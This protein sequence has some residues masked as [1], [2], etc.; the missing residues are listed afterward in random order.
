MRVTI[1]HP[2]TRKNAMSDVET[3]AEP[4]TLMTQEDAACYCGMSLD[5]FRKKCPG[6]L[7][8]AGP[9]R[10]GRRYLRDRLDAWLASLRSPQEDRVPLS[11][12]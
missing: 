1:K 9:A 6:T 3:I 2:T 12:G 4:D 7:A 5:E 10:K 11:E 8:I